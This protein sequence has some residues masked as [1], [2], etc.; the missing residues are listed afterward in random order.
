M[1]PQKIIINFHNK[2]KVEFYGAIISVEMEKNSVVFLSWY[3]CQTDGSSATRSR[4]RFV[5]LTKIASIAEYDCGNSFV[6]DVTKKHEISN[7]STN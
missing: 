7:R 6:L 2:T 4:L 3:N 1:K 5:D